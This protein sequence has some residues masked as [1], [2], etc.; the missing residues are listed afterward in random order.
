MY[1]L[2][3]LT[4]TKLKLTINVEKLSAFTQ[5]V[6]FLLFDITGADLTPYYLY[7]EDAENFHKMYKDVC[8]VSTPG[9][10]EKCKK[11]CDDYFF[12]PARGE[13]RGIGGIFF[14]DLSSMKTFQYPNL[15]VQKKVEKRV[16]KEV[17]QEVEKKGE[18]ISSTSGQDG[19]ENLEGNKRKLHQIDADLD[20]A[21]EFTQSVCSSFMPSYLPIARKRRNIPYTEE[22]VR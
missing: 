12:L 15:E 22:Q 7:F 3:F 14:D 13:H 19:E 21:M 9:T 4:R 2:F 16:Q 1:N 11:W 5:Y 6:M 20:N 17:E 8:D 10:Y 18:S